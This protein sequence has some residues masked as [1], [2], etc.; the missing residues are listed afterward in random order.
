MTDIVPNPPPEDQS[1]DINPE[2][3]VIESPPPPPVG[4]VADG[5]L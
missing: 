5:D 4:L 1:V 2:P 3:P